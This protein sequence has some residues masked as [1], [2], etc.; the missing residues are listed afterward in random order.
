MGFRVNLYGPVTTILLVGV[1]IFS[2]V[3]ALRKVRTDQPIK[4]IPTPAVTKPKGS[5]NSFQGILNGATH[6][7][8]RLLMSART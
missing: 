2:L 8:R 4:K 7:N 3:P 1:E 6:C 5:R